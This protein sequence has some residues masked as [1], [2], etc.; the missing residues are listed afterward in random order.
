MSKDK[1]K[2]SPIHDKKAII[3]MMDELKPEEMAEVVELI[4][5]KQ[6][7]NQTAL[8]IVISQL[9]E[10]IEKSAH[11]DASTIRTG[12]YRIGLTKAIE[13]CEQAKEMEKE[14]MI[15]SYVKGHDNKDFSCYDADPYSD[16]KQYYNETYVGN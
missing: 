6:P 4:K 5:S 12:D 16:A 2:K 1:F 10:Q 11:K 9:K 13:F 14:Q 15:K 8:D 3:S 7:K